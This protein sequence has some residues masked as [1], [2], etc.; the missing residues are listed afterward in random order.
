MK[1]HKNKN[2]YKLKYIKTINDANLIG[3]YELIMSIKNKIV[4]NTLIDNI[5]NK[6]Q[7][8]CYTSS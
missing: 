8:Y 2:V 7:N 5:N 3:E 4:Y 6:K 1:K